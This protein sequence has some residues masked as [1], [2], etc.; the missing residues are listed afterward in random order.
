MPLTFRT[1][2]SQYQV[3]SYNNFYVAPPPTIYAINSAYSTLS[4][5][6]NISFNFNYQNSNI[7]TDSTGQYIYVTQ[8]STTNFL[9]YSS[10]YGATFANVTFPALSLV[11]YSQ[12]ACDSTGKYVWVT[13]NN[14]SIYFSQNGGTAS[15]PTFASLSGTIGPYGVGV[16]SDGT[17]VCI[18]SANQNNCYYISNGTSATPTVNTSTGSTGSTGGNAAYL[19]SSSNLQYIYFGQANAA[20]IAYSS[21]YG[22]TFSSS[23]TPSQTSIGESVSCDS[24]GQYVA[25]TDG[26]NIYFN[27][28]DSRTG[29]FSWLLLNSSGNIWRNLSV[30]LR[31]DYIIIIASGTNASPFTNNLYAGISLISGCKT[32]ANW[33]WGPIRSDQTYSGITYLSSNNTFYA[34]GSSSVISG[35]LTVTNSNKINSV[36]FNSGSPVSFNTTALSSNCN[37]L[38]SS[39][40]AT[41]SGNYGILYN[42]SVTST[43]GINYTVLAF[44]ST[45]NSYTINYT[46]NTSFSNVIYVLAVGGGGSGGTNVGG[47]G[48]GGGVYTGAYT[49][50]SIGNG[51]ITITVGAGGI[52]ASSSGFGNNGANTTVIS[53]S[54]TSISATA[55]GGGMGVNNAGNGGSAGAGG[56]SGYPSLAGFT[57]VDAGGSGSGNLG[58]GGGGAGAIGTTAN[59]G[60]APGPGGAGVLITNTSLGGYTA[61]YGVKDLLLTGTSVGAASISSMYFGGG[62]GGGVNAI[63]PNIGA[64]GGI[65][66]SGGGGGSS[67]GGT[68]G[69]TSI[70]QGANG[71]ANTSGGNAGAN[72]GSG[73]GG[74]QVNSAGNGGSGIVIIAFRN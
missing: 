68:G 26:T 1:S 33:S 10:N 64:N 41:T 12:I 20:Y 16:S 50:S 69:A 47:G 23:V 56:S 25:Y 52:G 15:A 62:G 71:A 70:N 72:T 3:T 74:A 30:V 35:Q 28:N 7:V 61:L 44:G 54:G 67:G 49:V 42:S 39:A 18:I 40:L 6:S 60:V 51:A 57:T 43:N 66:G 59:A 9:Y 53:T 38:S 19:S 55:T 14:G 4:G 46:A 2:G 63:S 5:S 31:G 45:S 11:W 21:N 37:T 29:S 73:G 34:V 22:Q 65:G 58:G 36:V 27:I 24:T 17:R 48:G 13:A 32:A 8:N